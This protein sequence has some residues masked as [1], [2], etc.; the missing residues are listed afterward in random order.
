MT[1]YIFCKN[2][3]QKFKSPIQVKNLENPDVNFQN[4]PSNCPLCGQSME[5]KK[6]DMFN[7]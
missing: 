3:N 7:E 4:V 5:L 2:C 1:T 6:E